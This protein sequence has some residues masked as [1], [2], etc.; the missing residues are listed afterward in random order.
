VDKL[1]TGT[2]QLL[3]SGLSGN[4]VGVAVI[5]SGVTDSADL[6]DGGARLAYSE[7]LVGGTAAD[8]FGHGTHVA[9]IIIGNGARST[10]TAFSNTIAGIAPR[11]NIISLNALNDSGAGTDTTVIAAINR[12][13]ELRG[14]FNIRI[15][16]LS[17]G[18]PV[19]ESFR[20]DPLCRAVEAGW[21]A[22]I[23]VVV[24]AG[25]Q[26]RNNDFGT[27]GYGM[28]GSPGNSPYVITVG[29]M[30]TLGTLTRSDDEIATY[31]SKGPTLIDRIV[32][33]DLVAPGNQIVSVMA[34]H[35]FL[36]NN[37]PTTRVAQSS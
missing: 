17:L 32:K 11:V 3:T 10:G 22:G 9:G 8:G 7:S 29:A 13:I 26:G 28:I 37:Y 6:R 12:A 25:N 2:Q 36:G 23:V 31:S 30:K 34:A 4:S 21:R 20:V 5:D 33:R 14:R 18:R 1:F 35:N 15:I 16:N 27:Y 24:A 19:F